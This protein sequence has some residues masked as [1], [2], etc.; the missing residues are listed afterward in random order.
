MV[1]CVLGLGGPRSADFPLRRAHVGRAFVEHVAK[2]HGFPAWRPASGALADLSEHGS[3][4]VLCRLWPE[5]GLATGE[6]GGQAAR[7]CLLY[8]GI[9]SLAHVAIVHAEPRKLCGQF[10]LVEGAEMTPLWAKGVVDAFAGSKALRQLL[11]LQIGVGSRGRGNT[12]PTLEEFGEAQL[13][14]R[15]ATTVVESVFPQAYETLQ[16]RWFGPGAITEGKLQQ[17]VLVKDL[18]RG[19]LKLPERP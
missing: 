8:L 13:H 19:A 2:A 15:D 18:R 4:L 5:G 17:R 14:A 11:R 6:A 12:A 3:G 10:A 7:R 16:K 9:R 1:R